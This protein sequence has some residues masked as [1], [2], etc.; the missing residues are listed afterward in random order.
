MRKIA[1]LLLVFSIG[2]AHAQQANDYNYSRPRSYNNGN[3]PDNNVN[4]VNSAANDDDYSQIRIVDSTQEVRADLLPYKTDPKVKNDRYYFWC[5]KNVIHSTQGGFNGKLLNGHYVAFYPDKNLK[6]E[7]DF[8]RGLKNGVWK[9]W[10]R[11]GDITNLITWN[12]G[13]VVPDNQQPV[14]K[15]IP[16]FNKKDSQPQTTPP[17]NSNQ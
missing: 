17:A 4:R 1:L 15:K 10:N 8:D 7:G 6:E 13:I 14:W 3:R 5:F 9:T 12:Q 11:K 16:F 2:K